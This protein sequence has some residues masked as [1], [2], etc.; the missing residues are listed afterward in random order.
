MFYIIAESVVE[1]S[2]NEKAAQDHDWW[3]KSWCLGPPEV[4]C[5]REAQF[6]NGFENSGLI[7]FLSTVAWVVGCV[8]D[9]PYE[10]GV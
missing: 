9:E 5:A 3:V 1:L 2:T 10:R 4:N 7:G 8:A 6:L